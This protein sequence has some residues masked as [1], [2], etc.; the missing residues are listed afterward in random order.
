[1]SLPDISK[2][3]TKNVQTMSYL[4]SKCSSLSSLPDISKWNTK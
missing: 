2:W 4:F 3:N 1:M